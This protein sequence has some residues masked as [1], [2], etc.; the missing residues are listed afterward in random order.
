[1]TEQAIERL[2]KIDRTKDR[3]IG[4]LHG[5]EHRVTDLFG[6]VESRVEEIFNTVSELAEDWS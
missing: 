2:F 3:V 6:R 5:L 1:M 4:A